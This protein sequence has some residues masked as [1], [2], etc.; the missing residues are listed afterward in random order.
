MLHIILTISNDHFP[1]NFNYLVY[2][3]WIADAFLKKLKL[4][5]YILFR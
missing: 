4:K 3:R 2:G 5:Y 1:N